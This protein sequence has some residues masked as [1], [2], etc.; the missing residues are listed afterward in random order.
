MS[1]LVWENFLCQVDEIGKLRVNEAC[2]KLLFDVL[3]AKENKQGQEKLLKEMGNSKKVTEMK[4]TRRRVKKPK[5][6]KI[7]TRMIAVVILIVIVTMTATMSVS[8]TTM[9]ILSLKLTNKLI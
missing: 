7:T 2:F 9:K 6:P 4:K 8:Q 5:K 1:V 3:E